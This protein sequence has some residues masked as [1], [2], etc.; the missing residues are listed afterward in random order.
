MLTI[1]KITEEVRVFIHTS[2][3]LAIIGK[4]KT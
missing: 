1:G 4:Q 3:L 2:Q